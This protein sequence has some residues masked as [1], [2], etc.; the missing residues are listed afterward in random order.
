MLTHAAALCSDAQTMPALTVRPDAAT[1]ARLD[2]F[3]AKLRAETPGLRVSRNAAAL[4][5]ITRALDASGI[6][7]A[8]E[9][10]LKRAAPVAKKGAKRKA[11]KP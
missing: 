8:A 1:L 2:A 10:R 3:A 6:R 5:L 7:A 9:P 11:R 4:I